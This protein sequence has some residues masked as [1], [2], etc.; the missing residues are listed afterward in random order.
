MHLLIIGRK[1][2]LLFTNN[3]DEIFR[4]KRE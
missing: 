3:N 1:N 2:W 4:I